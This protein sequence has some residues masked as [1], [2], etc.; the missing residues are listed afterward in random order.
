MWRTLETDPG[1]DQEE[2]VE[3][4]FAEKADNIDL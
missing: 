1:M 4:W 2:F 3:N